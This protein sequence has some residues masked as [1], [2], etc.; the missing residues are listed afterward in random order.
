MGYRGACGVYYCKIKNATKC[1]KC[2]KSKRI[3]LAPEEC[4]W[5][6]V[7]SQIISYGSNQHGVRITERRRLVGFKSRDA[8]HKALCLYLYLMFLLMQSHEDGHE[9]G[10]SRFSFSLVVRGMDSSHTLELQK[11]PGLL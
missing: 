4:S 6:P 9:D 10:V 11:D 2:T 1:K 8:R 7:V 5:S 3:W